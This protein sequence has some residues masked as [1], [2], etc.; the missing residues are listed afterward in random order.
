MGLIRVLGP[1]QAVEGGG[2][3][4]QPFEEFVKDRF[5]IGDKAFVKDETSVITRCLA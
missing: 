4:E 5:I 2:S 1:R 3:F